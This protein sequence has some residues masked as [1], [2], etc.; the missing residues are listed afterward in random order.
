M[1]AHVESKAGHD[2][3]VRGAQHGQRLAVALLLGRQQGPA[4]ALELG[5]HLIRFLEQQLEPVVGH[6]PAQFVEDCV[7][8]QALRGRGHQQG[9]VDG[10][11]PQSEVADHAIDVHA[12][13][14][15]V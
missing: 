6:R 2:G 8:A 11:V 4:E 12:V 13:A 7:D 3:L 1:V 15:L 14:D 5:A 9:W 10:R